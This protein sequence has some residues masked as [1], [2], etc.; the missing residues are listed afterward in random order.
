[1]KRY[2]EITDD[3]IEFLKSYPFPWSFLGKKSDSFILPD[4]LDVEKYDFISIRVASECLPIQL[5]H[6]P[7][8]PPFPLFLT[9]A[10]TS[11]NSES[12]TLTEAREY[13]PWVE[14]IDGW[15]CD[16]LPSDIFSLDANGE[17]LYLRK[18]YGI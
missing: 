18:N 2:I 17:I 8:I 14:W 9:S 11:G 12:K 3:Q 10:N 7:T 6:H 4:F 16:Q 13:F 1:M 15:M 5:S